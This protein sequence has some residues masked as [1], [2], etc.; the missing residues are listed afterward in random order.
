MNF[1]VSTYWGLEHWNDWKWQEKNAVRSTER[2]FELFPKLSDNAKHQIENSTQHLRFKL[3]PYLLSL[4]QVDR[5][6][7]PLENDPIWNQFVPTFDKKAEAQ[8]DISSFAENWEMPEEMVNPILQHKYRNRV[9]FRIQNSC[10]AYCMYCFEAK[11]VLDKRPTKESLK[12]KYFDESIEY[13]KNHREVSEVVISGGEPLVLSNDKLGYILAE[14]RKLPQIVAIRIQT[15]AFVHNPFRMDDE[16]IQLLKNFDVTAMAFHISHP[17]EISKDCEKIIQR[18]ADF[19]CRTMLLSHI[20]LLKGINDSESV[21]AELFMKIYA[22]KI[23]PYYLLHAMPDTVGASKFR[24]SV[25]KGV[26]LLKKIKR[27]YSNPALPEYVI[28]H[29]K[30]KHTVPQELVGT[31]EFIYENGY[32]E[33]L[34][35]KGE[36]CTYEDSENAEDLRLKEIYFESEKMSVG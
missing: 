16:F 11:R 27:N 19:G 25:R 21:L 2:L 12:P 33:F 31:S 26:H 36:W 32:I 28:V 7:N 20:P 1:P 14:I 10:L 30:G 6:Q 23:K 3:T 13:I 29:K 34:N 35:W 4:I 17:K 24:T 5:F 8:I 22:L 15:R 9:N 18:F